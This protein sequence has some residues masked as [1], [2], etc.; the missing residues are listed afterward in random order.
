MEMRKGREKSNIIRYGG[1]RREAK[2]ARN[3]GRNMQQYGVGNWESEPLES[4]RQQGFERLQRPNGYGIS[5]NDKQ[6]RDGM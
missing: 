1:D 3:L 5:Q 2:M 4:S 6:W